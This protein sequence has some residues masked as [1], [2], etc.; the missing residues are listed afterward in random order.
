MRTALSLG[1]AVLAGCASAQPRD[2][3][4]FSIRRVPV[5]G[6]S[7]PTDDGRSVEKQ[8]VRVVVANTACETND[9]MA[10]PMTRAST[11]ERPAGGMSTASGL[12]SLPYIPNACPV[13][14]GP[15]ANRS[16]PAGL[17]KPARITPVPPRP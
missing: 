17:V 10:V 2:A 1:L 12:R 14:A 16:V 7:A 4:E 3:R 15:L 5:A 13:T 11:A 8:A 6:V 9:P